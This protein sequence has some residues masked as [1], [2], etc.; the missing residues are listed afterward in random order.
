MSEKNWVYHLPV[1]DSDR[2]NKEMMVYS[3]WSGHRNFAYDYVCFKKPQ[4][5]VELGSYYGCSAFA[6]LQAIKD[7]SLDSEF[8]G[9]DT[10]Q[11]D[12][13]TQKDY[14]EDIYTQYKRIQDSC[15]NNQNANML[16]M[17]FDKA[18]RVF[19]DKSIDLLHIDGSHT[20]ENVKHDFLSWKD[21]VKEDGVVFFHDIGK[22]EL[23]GEVMGSHIFWEE[24]KQE[25][26]HTIEFPFSFGLGVLFFSEREYQKMIAGVDL[27]S[28]QSLVNYADVKN[29]D[30][31]RKYYFEIREFKKYNAFLKEQIQINSEHLDKYQKDVGEK[32]QYIARIEQE[33]GNLKKQYQICTAEIE[34]LTNTRTD[35]VTAFEKT[36]AGKDC[37][38]DELEKQRKADILGKNKYIAELKQALEGCQVNISGKD[39]YIAELK[40]TISD[41]QTDNSEKDGYITELRQVI[42]DYQADVSGKDGYIAE[43]RQ[44]IA[45]YQK[46]ISGK[47]AYII[48][49]GETIRHYQV[50]ISGK[51][52][53]IE[54]L[55]KDIAGYQKDT[56]EKDAYI[57]ELGEIIQRYQADVKSKEIYIRELL[58]QAEEWEKHSN[59]KESYI[60]ELLNDIE[61]YNEIFQGKDSY[62]SELELGR[63][64]LNEQLKTGQGLL[65]ERE[66]HIAQQQEQITK[67]KRH[68]SILEAALNKVPF[69]KYIYKKL[70]N[71]DEGNKNE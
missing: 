21:K 32:K 22:D 4:K 36:I 56:A 47:D 19:A 46:D 68:I 50:D 41:Y 8:Y 59:R 57:I 53:Y 40:R 26:A 7:K 16:R 39:E 30:M 42:A 14:Q 15:F 31:I 37:Y 71:A 33:Q 20:Y 45:S 9:I 65:M 69:G 12:S 29:K 28:Y 5:I 17:T 54:N 35:T 55:Q 63:E 49:L 11:G 61:R 24:V 38:I 62:I 3:P 10:W 66:M 52:G 6:F 58:V 13:F 43:L 44:V 34:Q 64:M 67:M 48:E 1:F 18:I 70:E 27:L 25:Y 51:E 60:K 23:L 2:Y